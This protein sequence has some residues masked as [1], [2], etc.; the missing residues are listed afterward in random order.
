M[1]D[2]MFLWQL[3]ISMFYCSLLY[4][5]FWSYCSQPLGRLNSF[6][7]LY[8]L[9]PF[10]TFNSSLC[11]L[12]NCINPSI[13]FLWSFLLVWNRCIFI[14]YLIKTLG[15]TRNIASSSC[16]HIFRDSAK[17]TNFNYD[18]GIANSELLTTFSL[19]IWLSQHAWLLVSVPFA[20]DNS[21]SVSFQPYVT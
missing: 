4:F 10:K 9:F 2:F 14:I 12:F 19:I 11:H 21:I 1:L 16:Q 3:V 5:H 8:I 18:C 13:S 20:N 17:V 15:W 7:C 6:I